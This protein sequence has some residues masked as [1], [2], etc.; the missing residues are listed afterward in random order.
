MQHVRGERRGTAN[1]TQRHIAAPEARNLGG[2]DQ[3]NTVPKRDER[4]H[5][6][7]RIRA[8]RDM[9]PAEGVNEVLDR[10]ACAQVRFGNEQNQWVENQL[11]RRYDLYMHQRVSDGNDRANGI[12][13]NDLRMDSV[14]MAAING[15]RRIKKIVAHPTDLLMQWNFVELH[16]DIRVCCLVACESFSQP[17]V[18]GAIRHAE[19][20]M[21]AMAQGGGSGARSTLLHQRDRTPCVVEQDLT[22][23]RDSCAACVSFEQGTPSSRSISR[24]A[25]DNGDSSVCNRL[26]ARAN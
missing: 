2:A 5:G 24:I 23:A 10:G 6:A 7:E 15:D 19:A 26:A 13:R 18:R 9:R 22:R 8:K 17:A 11:D 4:Q 16:R 12:A 21:V 3:A 25:R 1:R 14:T 20:Q